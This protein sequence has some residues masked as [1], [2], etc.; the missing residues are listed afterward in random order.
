M[1]TEKD[2]EKIT[3]KVSSKKNNKVEN[4]SNKKIKDDLKSKDIDD[5]DVVESKKSRTTKKV[6]VEK[7]PSKKTETKKAN[8]KKIVD[9]DSIKD[10]AAE[11]K[12]A[13][14]KKTSVKKTEDKKAESKKVEPK[15][16]EDN[17]SVNKKIDNKSEEKVS[18][19]KTSSKKTVNKAEVVNKK[20][21]SSSKKDSK[22]DSKKETSVKETTSSRKSKNDSKKGLANTSDAIIE[23]ASKELDNTGTVV[24]LKDANYTSEILKNDKLIS[25]T[26][27]S[28]KDEA[29]KDTKVKDKKE[30]VFLDGKFK[31]DI[32]DL[33]IIIVITAIISC[34]FTGVVINY[35]YKK[36][37]TFIDSNLAQDQGVKDF[38]SLYEEILVNYYEE[39]DADALIK[40][41][42]K[43]MMSFLEDTY[44][45][46]LSDSE[47]EDLNEMLDSSYDG[48][49][50]VVQLNKIV[51]IYKNSPASK[52]GIKVG[53]EVIK[54]NG[55]EITAENYVDISKFLKHD[56]NNE[57]VVKRN[58][59]ELTFNVSM[60]KVNVPT[61][62]STVINSKE[63]K[64]GYIKLSSFSNNSYA[65]FN[66]SFIEV[67][68]EGIDS[69]II[70]LRS[71][72]GG[73][74]KAAF[75]IASEF[76][77]KDEVIYSLEQKG[78]VTTYKDTTKNKK[79]YKVVVLVN[80]STASASEILAAALH[81][82]YGATIVGKTTFGKG[83]VQTLK[84]FD[85]SIVKYTSAKWLRPNGECIDGIGIVPDYEVDIVYDN[86]QIYDKQLD[87]AI[88]LL[89]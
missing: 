25:V 6:D 88:E 64:I 37:G 40:S 85:D 19:K 9:K 60:D 33:L 38:L 63:K 89:S 27:I 48:I 8:D 28:N 78:K 34:V 87:K 76:I 46:Y 31:L 3:N 41:G 55:T 26:K 32:L 43:G 80:N 36:A 29:K 75:D 74:L 44:S 10:K 12:K 5:K 13:S 1:S 20:T 51:G 61:T 79:D 57:I 52:E 59:E 2:T 58:G 72:S 11:S 84:Q 77:E 45:I 35:Q 50:I 18:S 54:I 17:K 66:E 42:M 86:S 68:K 65:D 53:D 7:A 47:S 14:S 24:K 23:L 82:S 22:K 62:S 67:E 70:D 73:Y 15:K 16:V 69:L 71:N 49:G 56:E 81:D 4:K 83:K 30:K 21:S 39:V